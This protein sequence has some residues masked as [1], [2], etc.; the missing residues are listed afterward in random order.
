MVQ[1]ALLQADLELDGGRFGHDIAVDF[2]WREI[3]RIEPGP[4][5]AACA[6]PTRCDSACT[7]A[8]SV[9][10]LAGEQNHRRGNKKCRHC[11]TLLSPS[12]VKLYGRVIAGIAAI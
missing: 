6:A 12:A 2:G 4:F 5:G 8:P 7:A 9:R 11:E 3:G 1:Q 10:S